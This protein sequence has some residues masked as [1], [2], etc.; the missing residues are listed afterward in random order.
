MC[1]IGLHC[2]SLAFLFGVELNSTRC[3]AQPAIDAQVVLQICEALSEQSPEKMPRIVLPTAGVSFVEIYGRLANLLEGCLSATETKRNS[4]GV[5]FLVQ[6][7]RYESNWYFS[8]DEKSIRSINID[9]YR[10]VTVADDGIWQSPYGVPVSAAGPG[11]VVPI[12]P[13]KTINLP[14]ANASPSEPNTVEFFYATNRV[15]SSDAVILEEKHSGR[16]EWQLCL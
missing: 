8:T 16:G 5:T 1:Q 15:E 3:S 13:P 12:G 14:K 11:A 4:D 6:N 10:P 2:L 7:T 9:T